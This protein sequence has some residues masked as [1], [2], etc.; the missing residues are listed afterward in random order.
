MNPTDTQ[1]AG[2]PGENTQDPSPAARVITD[3]IAAISQGRADHVRALTDP[4]VT[5]RPA[6]RPARSFYQGHAETI[7]LLADLRAAYGPY[8]TEIDIL[9][10]ETDRTGTRVT[11]RTSV[12]R[13][14]PHGAQP[15]PAI[16][17]TF[18]LRNG[19]VTAVESRPQAR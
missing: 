11:A 9:T 17:S 2:P 14:P 3:L 19:L 13:E 5:W 10:T 12:G 8:R 4:D 6:T 7:G 18:T 1:M 16:V 15:M